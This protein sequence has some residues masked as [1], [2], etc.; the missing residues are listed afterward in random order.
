MCLEVLLPSI[1]SVLCKEA[2]SSSEPEKQARAVLVST[3]NPS[4]GGRNWALHKVNKQTSRASDDVRRPCAWIC[5]RRESNRQHDHL[6][7]I[8]TSSDRRMSAIPCNDRQR[9]L[10]TTRLRRQN[11]SVSLTPRSEPSAHVS[12]A[13]PTVC[14]CALH[15]GQTLRIAG[16]F[17]S[18]A[19]FRI[20]KG[21]EQAKVWRI[22]YFVNSPK[23]RADGPC[24]Q[25]E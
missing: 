24:E 14:I 7:T 15:A 2:P 20:T 9:L 11:P 13:L 3:T 4:F 18:E 19:V 8:Y 25:G 10:A 6:I 1:I 16:C 17:I 22:Q 23:R 21:S 12:I 5:Q